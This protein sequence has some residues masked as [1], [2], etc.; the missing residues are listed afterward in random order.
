MFVEQL[1]NITEKKNMLHFLKI[2]ELELDDLK[3]I[4]MFDKR[5][6]IEEAQRLMGWPD[7]KIR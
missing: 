4:F 2:F 6:L 5:K 3:K 1:L 7:E